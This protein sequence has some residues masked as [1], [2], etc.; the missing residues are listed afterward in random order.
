MQSEGC[1]GILKSVQKNLM[2]AL[3]L[4]D[5]SNIQVSKEFDD[6]AITVK[7]IL[8]GLCIKTAAHRV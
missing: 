5:F 6:L 4:L 3:E 8:P 7:A 1:F 2:S